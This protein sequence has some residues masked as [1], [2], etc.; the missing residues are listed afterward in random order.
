MGQEAFSLELFINIP[1]QEERKPVSFLSFELISS[2]LD[3]LPFGI[4][5]IDEYN[6]VK[7]VNPTLI[8]L[9]NREYNEIKYRDISST[10]FSSDITSLIIKVNE[11][12]Q[13]SE[14]GT[15]VALRNGTEINVWIHAVVVGF[16]EETCILLIVLPDE[17][18]EE[19]ASE[20]KDIEKLKEG[21]IQILKTL[22]DIN[23]SPVI[24]L[25]SE[26]SIILAN[27][28]ISELIGVSSDQLEGQKLS[29]IGINIPIL[30]SGCES[31]EVLPDKLSIESPYGIQEFSAILLNN[32][33]DGVKQS[34]LILNSAI[35]NV[36]DTL[37]DLK[38]IETHEVTELVSSASYELNVSASHVSDSGIGMDSNNPIL[39]PIPAISII[40]G[41]LKQ[42]N[43]EFFQWT[44]VEDEIL[45]ELS[46]T[47]V[48]NLV[49][50]K[51]YPDQVFSSLFPAG[52]RY[53]R[54]HFVPNQN[55]SNT[56]KGYFIDLSD[57]Y[58]KISALETESETLKREISETRDRISTDTH[59]DIFTDERG[60]QI[61][62]V[63]FDLSGGRYAMDIGMVREV[64]DMLPI[65]P[66]PKTPP[67]IIGIINLRGE[68]THIIDLGI[69]LGEGLKKDRSGQKIII[70]PTDAAHGEHL[71]II[72][73]NVRSVTEIGVKQVTSL[74]D[75]IN[76]RIQTTI[77]GVIK[78]TH[79]ELNEKHED[80]KKGDNLVIWLDMKDIL[81]RLAGHR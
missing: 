62:I 71:G 25:D 22:I 63:E 1:E 9:L 20:G 65:T 49:Q 45:P 52:M 19:V 29:D 28:G 59:K 56:G 32:V 3:R 30:T 16:D 44:G 33:S 18:K 15:K 50:S 10:G 17:E 38:N 60:A 57:A 74:G 48:S 14:I 26:R 80:D 5:I 75:E 6:I 11:T 2:I 34:L 78:I 67:Y 4:G 55:T 70:I 64:V 76:A 79:D 40:E 51:R 41:E 72:V 68:V 13:A 31:I 47:L 53:Y 35:G 37:D 54:I 81:N 21:N 46:S 23:P 27:E 73:D 12:Q 66:I 42:I 7:Y 43:K 36:T 39:C 61:D 24:L 58:K 77:K 8:S 69:L